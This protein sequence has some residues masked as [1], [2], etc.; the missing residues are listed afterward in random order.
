MLQYIKF[1]HTRFFL[2]KQHFFRHNYRAYNG[3]SKGVVHMKL[4]ELIKNILTQMYQRC[5]Q[6]SF[7]LENVDKKVMKTIGKE[8][9]SD[10]QGRACRHSESGTVGE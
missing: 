9:E 3:K 2:T 8:C 7:G 10:E 6:E 1:Y 4:N 5:L